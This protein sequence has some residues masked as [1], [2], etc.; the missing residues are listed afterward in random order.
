MKF[1]F[2]GHLFTLA[3]SLRARKII[4]TLFVF[5]AVVIASEA[6]LPDG[7]RPEGLP[8]E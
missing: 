6:R 3:F 8:K 2:D 5:I 1:L 4:K 7:Q